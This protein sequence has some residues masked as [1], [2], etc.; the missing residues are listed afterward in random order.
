MK[1]ESRAGLKKAYFVLWICAGGFLLL[2][3]ASTAIGLFSENDTLLLIGL[4]LLPAVGFVEGATLLLSGSVSFGLVLLFAAAAYLA[5]M[6]V[7]F[8]AAKKRPCAMLCLFLFLAADPLTLSLSPNSEILILLT[9]M[10]PYG[11]G[12]FLGTA[13]VLAAFIVGAV[14]KKSEKERDRAAASAGTGEINAAGMPGAGSAA[15]AADEIVFAGMQMPSD[16]NHFINE[17]NVMEN[18]VF[19]KI[20]R[21]EIPSER[22]YEDEDMIVIRDIEPKAKLHYLC[23]PKIHFALLSEMDG[24]K[25]ELLKRCFVKIASLEK[26]LGLEKGYRVIIN[27]GEDG[28]QSVHHLHIHLLGGEKL[29]GF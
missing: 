1:E 19:C 16:K 26:T 7:L 13:L 2:G 17:E 20:I 11:W 3:M 21:G 12:K 24:E 15:N 18:C 10:T 4:F 25:A 23:I 28:G 14:W 27:Q 5:G 22:L 29:T 8:L 9:V 6:A